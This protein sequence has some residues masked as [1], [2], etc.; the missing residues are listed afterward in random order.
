MAGETQRSEREALEGGVRRGFQ[1]RSHRCMPANRDYRA[2]VAERKVAAEAAH[3]RGSS[4][5]T[6]ARLTYRFNAAHE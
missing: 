4:A 2:E 6:W 1:L 5:P 3:P